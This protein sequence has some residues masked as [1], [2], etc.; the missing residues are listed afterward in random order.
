M[1]VLEKVQLSVR[2]YIAD[3]YISNRKEKMR[4]R[5]YGLQFQ[6]MF[7]LSEKK[8]YIGFVDTNGSIDNTL[9]LHDSKTIFHFQN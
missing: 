2:M 8:R 1:T 6:G 3:S 5:I 4:L 7:A 9:G